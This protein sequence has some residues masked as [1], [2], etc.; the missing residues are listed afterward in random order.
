MSNLKL[1]E[2]LTYIECYDWE[3]RTT[4]AKLETINKLLKEEQFLNLWNELLN[5]SNIKRIFTK[6]LDDMDKIIY[7]IEDKNIRSQIQL[8]IDRRT[9]EWLR[10]NVGIIENLLAKYQQEND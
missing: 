7:S 3:I 10:V 6:E 8:E 9:K 4:T 5:K 2:E 1:Y